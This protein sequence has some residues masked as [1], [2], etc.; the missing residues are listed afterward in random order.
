MGGDLHELLQARSGVVCAVG[1]GGKKSPLWRLASTHPERVA[2]TATVFIAHFPMQHGFSAVIAPEAALPA[3][4]AATDPARSVAYACACDKPDRYAGV[5]GRV[6]DA[7]HASGQFA[8]TYVKADGAR[9]R[10][11]KAPA[12]AEPVVPACCTTLLPVV[13]ARCIGEPLNERVAHRVE[14]VAAVTGLRGGE[15]LTAAHLGRLIASPEGMTKAAAGR[16]LVPVLNMV[17]D[18]YREAQARIAAEVALEMSARF[19]RVVLTCLAGTGDPVVGVV[20]R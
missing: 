8:A 17:D 10:F 4:V 18:P 9:M 19:D 16:R 11:V 2:V 3:E 6:I 14:R 13:S 7:V 20:H 15:I 5:D 12:D 1:A